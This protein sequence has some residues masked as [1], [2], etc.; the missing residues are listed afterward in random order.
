MRECIGS[1][2]VNQSP[3]LGL[4][5][6]LNIRHAIAV[7]VG[8]IIGSGIFLVPGVMMQAAGSAVLVYMA[9]IVG[10]LLSFFGALT[11]AELGA[12]K[13]EAGGEYVYLRDSYGPLVG[14]LD[15]WT[16][17]TIAKPASI[18]TI[19]LGTVRILGSFSEFGF[20]NA[21]VV[22]APVSIT[23]GHILAIGL[24]ICISA[25]N[26]CGVRTAGEFQLF[27]TA[28]KV[29]LILAIVVAAFSFSGGTWH[30]FTG[31]L[32][33]AKGGVSGFMIALVAALWAYDGWN[34]VSMLGGEIRNAERNIPIALTSGVLI[35]AVLYMCTNAGVQFVMSA[36]AVAAS[37][38]PATDAMQLAVGSLGTSVVSVGMALSMLVALNGSIMSGARVPFAVARDGYFFEC[39]A[40]V[41]PRFHTPSTA[42]IW[43]GSLASLLLILGGRFQQLFTLAV[44]AE[45]LFYMM[46]ASTVFVFRWR[47]PNASRPY[48]TWGYP[49]IPSLFVICALLLL[50]YTFKENVTN[51]LYGLAVILTGIP[52]FYGFSKRSPSIRH[53]KQ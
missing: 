44:F 15:A 34:G 2:N 1:R 42:I 8:N 38:R 43:Q 11:Y 46:A 52:V 18:G 37:D 6:E 25:I 27:L 12:M 13:P 45:W 33:T 23:N 49:Y 10:G 41:H 50:V 4:A 20:L 9:W 40:S 21:E 35:V 24:I 31:V 19:A 14:F 39:L 5:R 26:Y 36:S 3:I 47:E 28:L 51:S 48:K 7:V 29:V 30:N 17:F 16:W 32:P 22:R 53:K